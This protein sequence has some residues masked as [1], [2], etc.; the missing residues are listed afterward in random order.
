MNISAVIIIAVVIVVI[1][2][3]ITFIMNLIVIFITTLYTSL[4]KESNAWT[5]TMTSCSCARKTVWFKNISVMNINFIITVIYIDLITIFDFI[6]K[7]IVVFLS[8]FYC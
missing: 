6:A 2:I 7:Y 1:I 8:F 5:V 3:I 4:P